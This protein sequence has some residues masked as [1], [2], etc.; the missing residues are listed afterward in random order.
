MSK[1]SISFALKTFVTY[2]LLIAC[3]L[4]ACSKYG[5]SSD[6]AFR[7]DFSV[8]TV[9]FDT[10]FTTYGSATHRLMVY[11]PN[12]QAV[13]TRI[14]FPKSVPTAF[15]LNVDGKPLAEAC[16]VEI[17][18]RDSMFVFVEVTVNPQNSELPVWIL[19]SVLFE[20]NTNLQRVY[21]EA[22][23]QDVWLYR[24]ATIQ[25]GTWQGAKPYLIEGLLVIDTLQTL[26]ISE[27][28]RI[29]LRQG[30]NIC[31]KG[32]LIAEGSAEQP[33]VFS[34]SR[35]ESDYRYVPGQ[36]GSLRFATAGRDNLLRHVEIRDGTNGLLFGSPDAE[37][38]P[39]IRL[40][41]VS[42]HDMSYSG[43]MAFAADMEATNV[44]VANCN[45]YTVGLFC[46]GTA[47][48]THCTLANGYSS[49]IRRRGMSVLT[50][51]TE[52]QGQ[53]NAIPAVAG[54]YNSIIY[55]TMNEELS[56]GKDADCSFNYCLLKTAL[57]AS[58][59][60]FANVL[61]N[62]APLFLSPEKENF[63]LDSLSPACNAGN[64]NF[65][66]TTP[67]DMDGNSRTAD[68]APDLG[69]WERGY[70]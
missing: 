62:K 23:G 65:A 56:F 12:K 28:V 31:I 39:F 8:D 58:H 68:E 21:L 60:G 14:T 43:L 54:F 42:I 61:T 1:N 41:A 59:S 66:A 32:S 7:L 4:T 70:K 45:Y 22:Y 44:L 34:G 9:R 26:H 53:T 15:R 20:T 18:G 33:I 38:M 64:P 50:V 52:Y 10:V 13:R 6:P 16:E 36:W 55:G 35:L 30:A 48:F 3:A 51:D 5:L 69:A 29:F 40:D 19:D 46:G 17:A 2:C 27:G 49:G 67:T 11:N 63:R 47:Q 57:N 25:G 24:N 37:N